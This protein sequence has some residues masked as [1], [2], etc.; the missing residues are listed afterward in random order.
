MTEHEMDELVRDG[1]AWEALERMAGHDPEDLPYPPD[2]AERVER[3]TEE[4]DW[5]KVIVKWEIMDRPA[6]DT[7]ERG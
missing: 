5:S 2:I 1:D 4:T 7:D 6:P 3:M